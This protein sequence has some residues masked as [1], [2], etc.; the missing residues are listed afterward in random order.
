MVLMDIGEVAARS[1]AK[2]SALRYY[3]ALGL[4]ESLG[5]RGLRR[6]YGADALLRLAFIALGR[7][8][9]FSLAEIAAIF[10]RGGPRDLPRPALHAKADALEAKIA[11]LSALRTLLRHIAECPVP[12]HMEC[13]KFRKLL[14]EA[15][16]RRE[17]GA[18]EAARP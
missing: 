13:P 17:P 3:E 8:A 12:S 1:G 2:P 15:A 18:P 7:A 14:R 4:I 5:R 16:A 6:Q 9:G 11:E 10:A